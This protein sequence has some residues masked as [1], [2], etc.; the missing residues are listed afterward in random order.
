VTEYMDFLRAVVEHPDEDT[1][2]LML[3]DWL[4]ENPHAWPNG[5]AT[6]E[7][8]RAS[9]VVATGTRR[10]M[11]LRA[12]RWLE[13]NWRRLVPTLAGSV[14]I[15]GVHAHRRRGRQIRCRVRMGTTR[16]TVYHASVTLD[17]WKGFCSGLSMWSTYAYERIVSDAL[18]ID[19][20]ILFMF[21]PP[22]IRIGHPEPVSYADQVAQ[23][24]VAEDG[25]DG[26]DDL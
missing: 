24:V 18:Q 1:P 21:K 25:D 6:A 9:C 20:P 13:E 16:D 11:P 26:D 4:D 5:R 7:F 23:A 12:Y 14:P 22:P 10:A 19:Q 17:F 8:I 2:R 15:T 3:A